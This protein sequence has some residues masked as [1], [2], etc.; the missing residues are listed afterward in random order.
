MIE[1]SVFQ[2]EKDFPLK[3]SINRYDSVCF[4][5]QTNVFDKNLFHQ[6]NR[7]S[8]KVMVST[9]ITWFGVTKPLFINEKGLKLNVKNYRKYLQK[10]ISCN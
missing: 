7:Q 9:A 1:R 3:I 2:D 6:I 4:K 10:N 5:S 8:V